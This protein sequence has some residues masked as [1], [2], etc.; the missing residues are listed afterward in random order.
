[1]EPVFMLLAFASVVIALI[2]GILAS[3]YDHRYEIAIWVATIAIL[4]HTLFYFFDWSSTESVIVKVRAQD[5]L[6]FSIV[7]WVGV[8]VWSCM[9]IKPTKKRQHAPRLRETKL[10]TALDPAFVTESN[11]RLRRMDEWR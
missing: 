6:W 3:Q 8:L 10:A 5:R 1:M 4:L 7:T 9:A 11:L 2:P